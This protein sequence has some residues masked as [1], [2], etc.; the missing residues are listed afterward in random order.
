MSED[1]YD[2]I[3]VIEQIDIITGQ[4]MSYIKPGLLAT[5][6]HFSHLATY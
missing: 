5:G 2:V 3:D 1:A 4:M 6:I